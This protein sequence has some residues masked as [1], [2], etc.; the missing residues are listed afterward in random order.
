MSGFRLPLRNTVDRRKSGVWYSV[1][2]SKK[3]VLLKT[4]QHAVA[5]E[6]LK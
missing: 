6:Q 2:S 1:S 5:R 4:E 3:I